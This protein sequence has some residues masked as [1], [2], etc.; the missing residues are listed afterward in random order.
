MIFNKMGIDTND[1]L[2]AAST[3]W[4]FLP[5]KPGLVG[6]HCIGVDPYYLTHIAQAIGYHPEIILASRRI[7]NGMSNHVVYLLIKAMCK[8]KIHINGARVL[9]MGLSFKEN[10]PDIRNTR[11]ID[12]IKELES[13]ECVV[14]VYDPWVSKEEASEEF[15]FSPISKLNKASYDAIVIAVAHDQFKDMGIERI[16]LLAKPDNVIFDLKSIFP[17]SSVDLRL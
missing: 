14:D 9:L 15:G 3:K 12:L 4:N 2:K 10:C 7:N 17:I 13:M 8:K 6:G 1:V 5:F 11:I 16:K